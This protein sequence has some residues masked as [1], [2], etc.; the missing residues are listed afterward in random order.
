MLGKI[1]GGSGL[2]KIFEESLI[3]GSNT[4]EQIKDG[5]RL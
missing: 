3:Y 1:T 2:E 4:V 5:H